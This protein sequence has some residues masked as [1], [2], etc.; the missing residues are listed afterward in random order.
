MKKNMQI[1]MAMLIAAVC[2]AQNSSDL[3]EVLSLLEAAGQPAEVEQPAPGA[4]PE[5]AGTALEALAPQ[6]EKS[7]VSTYL[8]DQQ[9]EK[10][11]RAAETAA[12]D[13]VTASWNGLI[14]RDYQLSPAALEKMRLT[15]VEKSTDVSGLFPDVDFPEGSKA[16]YRP[17][18]KKLL[19]LNTAEN[20]ARLEA[21]LVALETPTASNEGQ[22]EIQ[23]RFV[24]FAEGALEEL[25]FGWSNPAD[26]D[27]YHLAGDW[28]VKDGENLF[29]D[30]LRGSG[31]VFTQPE[32]I[33]DETRA[34][35]DWTARRLQDGFSEDAGT[36][37]I[38]DV[39][40]DLDVLIRALDQT[41]GADVLSAPS[42]VTRAGRE[43][44]IQVGQTHYFPDVF[45]V[46]GSEGSIVHINY[47]DFEEH[48]M[49]VELSVTPELGEDGLIEM[50]LNPK[51]TELLGWR[52]YQV[53]PA[54]SAYTYFQYR[55]GQTFEHDAIV[56][57][58]PILRRREVKTSVT[59]EDGSS[60]GMGGL[61]SEE[62]ESFS[63]RVPVLGSIPLV[64]RLFRS[65]GE[66]TVKRNLMI[67]VTAHKVA[68]NGR[69]ISQQ[70]N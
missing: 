41:S 49:G 58:L 48:L 40:A 37:L 26:G 1:L 35:G 60:I 62:T 12:L 23:A 34:S 57:R 55:I 65:E 7:P 19:V 54:D 27:A 25:G 30:S 59:I 33:G 24:E 15:G 39:G 36:L 13:A 63:D 16:V 5:A 8:R 28:D 4:Q 32:S 3:N 50:D 70:A 14:L 64:G 6:A 9:T 44:T 52:G 21:L 11:R 61:I 69:I 68:P 22:I 20:T 17:V 2:S 43:A 31:D 47:T 66:R 53:A 45:E 38:K 46:G 67:F 42:I 10:E 29:A 51:I 56:A 18:L